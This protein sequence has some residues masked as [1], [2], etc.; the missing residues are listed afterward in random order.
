MRPPEIAAFTQAAQKYVVQA[1]GVELDGSEASL[2]FVDHYIA[3]AGGEPGRL[4]PEI[5]QLVAP[6][7]GAYFGELAIAKFGGRW[8]LPP[9][10]DGERPDPARW[11]AGLAPL[12]PRLPPLGV[13]AAAPSGGAV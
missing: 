9:A 13:A 11:P 4:R 6:A 2:A 1:V 12:E 3:S 10:S 5:L 7:L 8:R